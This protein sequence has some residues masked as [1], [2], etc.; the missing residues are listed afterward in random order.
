MTPGQS[1]RRIL[2]PVF[3]IFGQA[4]R[5]LFVDM[6]KVADWAAARIS[7]GAHVLEVGGGDGYFAELLLARRADIT[8]TLLDVASE[9]GTFVHPRHLGRLRLM[10]ETDI[11]EL[12]GRFDA[13]AVVDVVHHV[14]LP[15]R[16]AFLMSAADAA[17]RSGCGAIFVK[18][19]EPVGVRARLGLWADLFI[20]GDKGVSQ[21]PSREVAFPRFKLQ[22]R[23]MPDFPNYCLMFEPE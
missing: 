4:Y 17:A 3:P 5:R 21:I 7:R 12:E 18:D 14:P 20:T 13:M 22:E 10:P 8:I 2:G 23:A 11:S 6:G 19:I 1:A 16:G 9:I 15:R